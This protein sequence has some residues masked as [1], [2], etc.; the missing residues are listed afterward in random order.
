MTTEKEYWACSP[1][2]VASITVDQ[3]FQRFCLSIKETLSL[4][5]QAS[6]KDA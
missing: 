4:H 5:F 3:G 1:G 6:N 2:W